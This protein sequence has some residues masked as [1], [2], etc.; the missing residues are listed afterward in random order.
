M[1]KFLAI[2][3]ALICVFSTATIALAAGEKLNTC[4]FCGMQFENTAEGDAAFNNHYKDPNVCD[5]RARSCPWGC[6]ADFTTK[7]ALEEH[8]YSICTKYKAKCD[9]C[10]AANITEEHEAACK[11]EKKIPWS[12]IKDKVTEFI[13]GID[14]EG[15]I[16]KLKPALEKVIGF[17]SGIFA[18]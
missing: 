2:V 11:A 6:G 8:K 1:K 9:Y 13:S 5:V 15:I 16:A 12:L 17:V 4:E 10:G 18:K 7:E 3:L 14:F